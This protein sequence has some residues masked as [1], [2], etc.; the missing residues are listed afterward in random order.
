M[1]SLKPNHIIF[2]CIL[3]FCSSS[4]SATEKRID[5]NRCVNYSDSIPNKRIWSRAL[6]NG[7]LYGGSMALLYQTWY[8]NYPQSNFRSFDDWDEWLQTD[9]VGH[10]YSSYIL[11]CYGRAFW[12]NSGLT[13]KQQVWIGGLTGMGYQ[14]VIETLDGFSAGWGWSW[15]DVGANFLGSAIFIGEELAW[16]EQRISIKT[17]FHHKGYDDPVLEDRS[18]KLFGKNIAERA[19]KDY[20]GQTYWLSVNLEEFVKSGRLPKWL[21]LAVGYG[22][23]GMLGARRNQWQNSNGQHFDYSFVPRKRQWYLSPDIDLTKI[24][25][26]K[27]WLKTV[28]FVANALKFPAPA[29]ELSS[30]KLKMKW[31]YF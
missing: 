6:T 9:K 18:R 15:T 2:F 24:K 8:K 31:F 20:N 7:G 29:L 21:N 11:S 5:H 26:R 17:S 28:L 13:E 12:K 4:V 10:L 25:T 27:K 22:A 30:G 1:L 14:T 16:K 19:L 23:E 3:L